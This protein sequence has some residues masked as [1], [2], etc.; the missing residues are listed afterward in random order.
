[1][2]LTST[3]CSSFAISSSQPPVWLG[4]IAY[5]HVIRHFGVSSLSNIND[6]AEVEPATTSVLKMLPFLTDKK[7]TVLFTGVDSALTDV[8]SRMDKVCVT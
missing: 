2:S 7:S 6:P 3:A 8:V 4:S 5:S 1:M